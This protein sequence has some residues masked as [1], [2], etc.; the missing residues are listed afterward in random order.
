MRLNLAIILGIVLT[1][2]NGF[3]SQP[4]L[5]A[6]ADSLAPGVLKIIPS[7][8]KA[9]DTYSHPMPVPGLKSTE[10]DPNFASKKQTLFGQ[11]QG[12]VLFRDVWQYEIGILGLRQIRIQVTAKDGSKRAKNIWYLVYRIRD[13]GNGLTFEK[14]KQDPRFEHIE[15][16][17]VSDS[18]VQ[19][20]K[21][22]FL[23]RFSFEAWVRED[24]K[25]KKAVYRDQVNP[26]I[27]RLIQQREDPNLPLLDVF[28]MNTADI[29]VSKPAEDGV[30]GVAIWEN[31]DPRVDFV[32]VFVSG[33]TNAY[34]I[35]NKPDGTL[36]I[37]RKTLQLNFWRAGDSVMEVTDAIDYGIPMVDDFQE[38]IAICERYNLPGPVING[39][40]VSKTAEQ[41]VM[42][43]ECDAQVSLLNLKSPLVPMLDDGKLP[44]AVIASFAA[45]HITIP[46]DTTVKTEIKEL[47]WTI[48]VAGTSYV[49]HLEPQFW[50]PKPNGGI[51]F[52]K[53]LDY[54]WIYR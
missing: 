30:W 49:L 3:S 1:F 13:V 10:W 2:G 28:G 17:L 24:G 21:R 43:T 36:A 45:A 23:P 14:K 42:V 15:H 27:L 31:V 25:Y 54:L 50:E 35:S 18:K 16:K 4:E 52:I 40:E 39:Y 44:E 32:S 29:P 38:Q 5:L 41:N 26:K 11:T 37:K 34:R 48:D 7:S 8:P 19:P 47:K 51:R 33:L 12:V 53:S 6:Q 22:A 9:R 46:A 20:E